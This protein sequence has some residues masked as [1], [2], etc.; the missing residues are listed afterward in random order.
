VNALSACASGVAAAG[1]RAEFSLKLDFEEGQPWSAA[2]FGPLAFWLRSGANVIS[3]DIGD[4][5]LLP[6]LLPALPDSLQQL[7]L[8]RCAMEHETLAALLLRLREEKLAGLGRLELVLNGAADAHLLIAALAAVPRPTLDVRYR[9]AGT[10]D[11]LIAC[12]LALLCTPCICLGT[13]AGPAQC[14]LNLFTS[15][16]TNGWQ[17]S[18]ENGGLTA[19]VAAL[20]AAAAAA[21]SPGPCNHP[22][23]SLVHL[24]F[25]LGSFYAVTTPDGET[26]EPASSQS[27]SLAAAEPTA[28]L[29]SCGDVVR[30][31]ATLMKH[32]QSGFTAALLHML[33]SSPTSAQMPA[34]ALY[35]VASE[36]VAALGRTCSF[37][38]QWPRVVSLMLLTCH[39]AGEHAGS[40]QWLQS[41]PLLVSRALALLLRAATPV[42][43][44]PIFDKR[45]PPYP[46]AVKLCI[47]DA[48]LYVQ[49][50][51]T[52]AP[53]ALAEEGM[54]DAFASLLDD[55]R[56][57]GSMLRS[58]D[59]F[60]IC[61]NVLLCA[62]RASD[63]ALS[64]S[65]QLSV[66]AA[67]A[68]RLQAPS[69]T[70][71]ASTLKLEGH[72]HPLGVA[73]EI[74]Q[75]PDMKVLNALG[76]VKHTCDYCSAFG[77]HWR[78]T[79]GCDFDCCTACATTYGA[80]T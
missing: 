61:R 59:A 23:R 63:G 74:A 31:L 46:P 71:P 45:A 21:G 78:C 65:E 68:E 56:G 7:L 11:D 66:A 38:S 42:R 64:F 69:S 39:A 76:A 25:F 13:A 80:A 10:H 35:H 72:Q 60:A 55:K 3:L 40:L 12:H 28:A 52:L 54:H 75:W 9:P 44:A 36:C 24:L 49:T 17:R 37:S 14:L 70:A 67:D 33:L 62:E 29:L 48:A 8:S 34:D 19:I 51:C 41:H 47:A 18:L 2:A 20:H 58:A 1:R 4:D 26:F 32:D 6:L 22:V 79:A 53:V 15:A 43:A 73:G 77:T 57:A 5:A 16:T 30:S 50:V 27:S